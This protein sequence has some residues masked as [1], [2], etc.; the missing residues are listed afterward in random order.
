[1]PW[2]A[3]ETERRLDGTPIAVES[4]RRALDQELDAVAHPLQRNAWKLDAAAGLAEQAS[5]RLLAGEGRGP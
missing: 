3:R 1:V 2:R 5:E 4:L